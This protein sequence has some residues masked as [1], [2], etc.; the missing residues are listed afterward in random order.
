MNL[1][2]C[3]RLMEVAAERYS[4]H[5]TIVHQ[6]DN[7]V[8]ARIHIIDDIIVQFYYHEQ[9]GTTNFALIGW[10]N[11]LF[12]RDCIHGSWHMHPFDDPDNH[13]SSEMGSI[14]PTPDSFME[15]VIGWL[16][17]KKIL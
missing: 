3:I 4:L 5:L 9:S 11:R 16:I 14:Q 6:T 8:K 7:T 12:G 2:T 10:S 17:Q 1:E 15:E 13:D